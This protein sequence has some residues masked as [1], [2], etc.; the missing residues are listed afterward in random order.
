MRLADIVPGE[1]VSVWNIN[2]G[3]RTETYAIAL[4]KDRDR[5]W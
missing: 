4:P 3:Q 1:Q 2:N 5:S